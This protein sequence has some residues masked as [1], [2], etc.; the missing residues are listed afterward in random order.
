MTKSSLKGITFHDPSGMKRTFKNVSECH[1][2]SG[3]LAYM[4]THLQEAL[5]HCLQLEEM[6]SKVNGPNFPAI[7]GRRPVSAAGSGKENRTQSMMVRLCDQ[8]ERGISKD[9]RQYCF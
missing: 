2:L 9:T 3:T 1:T 8:S 4:W 5:K 6:L 7:I